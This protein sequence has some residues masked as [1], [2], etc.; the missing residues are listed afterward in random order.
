[1]LFIPVLFVGLYEYMDN[2]KR[3]RKKQRYIYLK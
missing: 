1:M 3:K 2:G